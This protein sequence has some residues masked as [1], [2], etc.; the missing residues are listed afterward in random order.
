MATA[1]REGN[2][3]KLTV[4]GSFVIDR[5]YEAATVI[6]VMTLAQAKALKD[7]LTSLTEGADVG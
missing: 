3:I 2:L 7:E 1:A 5:G 4:A 6:E